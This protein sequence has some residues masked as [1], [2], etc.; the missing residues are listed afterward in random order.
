[1]KYTMNN[2]LPGNSI[3]KG[4]AIYLFLTSIPCK[5][6]KNLVVKQSGIKRRIRKKA[7]QNA[8]LKQGPSV[9]VN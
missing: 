6:L 9:A 7:F 8:T 3:K 1:M 5:K 4:H 2:A